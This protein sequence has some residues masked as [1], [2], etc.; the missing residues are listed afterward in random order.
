[1][2]RQSEHTG[3]FDDLKQ[4]TA[5]TSF[6]HTRVTWV[7]SGL[8][9]LS[10]NL[11]LFLLLPHLIESPPSRSTI[12]TL[13]PQVNMIRIKRHER[14]KRKNV[15]MPEKPRQKPEELPQ[16]APRR[17]ISTKLRLPFKLNHRLPGG[18]G[19]LALPPFTSSALMN[20]SAPPNI[21]SVGQLDAPL[22]SLARIPP[23]YPLRARRRG[24]EGW[25][26][27]Q[28]VVNKSGQVVNIAIIEAQPTGIFEQSVKRCVSAWRFKPGTVDG[29]TVKTRV[30]TTIRFTLD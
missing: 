17:P 15:K 9:A 16:A 26:K 30:E 1:M 10:L 8:I 22:T 5:G 25:V 20:I 28:F 4:R 18:P 11:A 29:L 6:G 19:T 27:V 24:I 2:T 7:W 21:F 23:I 12:E 3:Y 14:V 13:V